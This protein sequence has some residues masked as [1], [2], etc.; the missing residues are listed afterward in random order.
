MLNQIKRKKEL[1]ARIA[2]LETSLSN[3]KKQLKEETTQ[4]HQ[5]GIDHLEEYLDEVNHRYTN[6]RDFLQ[7][8]RQELKELFARKK[9]ADRKNKDLREVIKEKRADSK[10]KHQ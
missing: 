4:E 3:L 1:E 2:D 9:A 7:I 10:R 6:L 5:E 8:V